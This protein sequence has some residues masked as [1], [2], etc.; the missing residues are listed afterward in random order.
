[1][2]NTEN[3][4]FDQDKRSK[5]YNLCPWPISFTLP[6][7]GGIQ[8][9]DAYNSTTINNGELVTMADNN[10]GMLC[11]KGEGNHARLYVDNPEFRKYVGFDNPESKKVQFVLN[12]DECQKILDLKTDA[13]FKKNVEEKVLLN[14]EKH[15]FMDYCRKHG[16]NVYSRVK[17]IEEYTGL[18][19]S[20]DN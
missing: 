4:V 7:S 12:D 1:M 8:W 10:E 15:I 11:G 6:N 17:F 19:F 5:V 18:K 9:I 2:V 3:V 20:R 14:H 13:A 16:L